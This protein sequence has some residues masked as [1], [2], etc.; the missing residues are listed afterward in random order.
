MDVSVAPGS[1]QTINVVAPYGP[2]TLPDTPAVR[3][4][5]KR[6]QANV[7]VSADGDIG[8]QTLDAVEKST[9]PGV[10]VPRTRIGSSTP[11][12]GV[13][14]DKIEAAT[15]TLEGQLGAVLEDHRTYFQDLSSN[16]GTQSP[17]TL[18]QVVANDQARGR[19]SMVSIKNDGGPSG[20]DAVIAKSPGV[21]SGLGTIAKGLVD[22]NPEVP[23]YL[24]FNHEPENDFPTLKGVIPQTT[25]DKFRAASDVFY[26]VLRP[27]LPPHVLI[28]DIFMQYTLTDAG[29]AEWGSTDKWMGST[30]DF[31]GFDDYFKGL[32]NIEAF[33]APRG[34]PFVIGEFGKSVSNAG[35]GA[36]QATWLQWYLD[37]FD[38]H[39]GRCLA[40]CWWN[41]VKMAPET[42]ALMGKRL[43]QA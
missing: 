23:I 8:Q 28:G 1:T 41:V 37:W 29:A 24:T 18:V 36:A 14:P 40:A 20:W 5:I 38:A 42:L 15:V 4:Q 26:E 35:S 17:G 9:A 11:P 6:I 43:L 16:S 7:G 33:M 21:M 3:A 30:G 12:A 13:T 10:T 22:T 32:D 19:G 25:R 34:L 2:F 31:V 39:P 27:Q